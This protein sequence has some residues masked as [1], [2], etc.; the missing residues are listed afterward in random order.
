MK[1]LVDPGL[2]LLVVETIN[3][4]EIDGCRLDHIESGSGKYKS[5][6]SRL[7]AADCCYG[8]SRK[9]KGDLLRAPLR[10]PIFRTIQSLTYQISN[11]HGVGRMNLA[12][13]VADLVE[14]VFTRP[15]PIQ[16]L[17]ERLHE[18]LKGSEPGIIRHDVAG[19][20]FG[21]FVQE[22]GDRFA[23]GQPE[24]PAPPVLQG[25]RRYGR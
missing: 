11:A 20:I 2:R 24:P 6:Q 25:S 15:K 23:V 21:A 1:V 19:G 4:I 16:F 3:E 13:C 17:T 18:S 8:Q 5:R 7:V 22:N 9:S 14:E 12:P 10:L